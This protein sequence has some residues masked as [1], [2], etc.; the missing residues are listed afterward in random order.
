MNARRSRDLKP[1]AQ[2]WGAEAVV[3]VIGSASRTV[4]SQLRSFLAALLNQIRIFKAQSGGFVSRAASASSAPEGRAQGYVTAF[5]FLQPCC[6]IL[7]LLVSSSVAVS[8]LSIAQQSAGADRQKASAFW[9]PR[10]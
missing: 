10:R 6:G 2:R 9:S 4:A 5:S 1:N 3:V 8:M 7:K